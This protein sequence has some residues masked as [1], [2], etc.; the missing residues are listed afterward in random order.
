MDKTHVRRFLREGLEGQSDE[1]GGMA[2]C[3]ER[4]DLSGW[5]VARTDWTFFT[6]RE[7]GDDTAEGRGLLEERQ[8]VD[9]ESVAGICC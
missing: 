2:A 5:E 8:E 7:C 1:R 3:G 6:G 4:R 9:D